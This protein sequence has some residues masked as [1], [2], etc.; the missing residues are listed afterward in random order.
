MKPKKLKPLK[1][2]GT[3][4]AKTL[5]PGAVQA[6]GTGASEPRLRAR[7]LF[8]TDVAAALGWGEHK[9]KRVVAEVHYWTDEALA[10]GYQQHLNYRVERTYLTEEQ[11]HLWAFLRDMPERH[12]ELEIA[13]YSRADGKPGKEPGTVAYVYYAFDREA[14]DGGPRVPVDVALAV[15]NDRYERGEAA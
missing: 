5:A 15:L 7:G 9:A 1:A 13:Y 6:E 14:K 3:I 12:P 2:I 8:Y 10:R 11:R 4:H